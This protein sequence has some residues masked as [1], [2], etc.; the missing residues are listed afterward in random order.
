MDCQHKLTYSPSC[1][2]YFVYSFKNLQAPAHTSKRGTAGLVDNWQN[3]IV[4][5]ITQIDEDSEEVIFA[6]AQS[7]DPTTKKRVYPP[8]SSNL[9]VGVTASKSLKSSRSVG[10]S[11]SSG[12]ASSSG[13]STRQ[14]QLKKEAEIVDVYVGLEDEDDSAERNAAR[15]SPVKGNTRLSKVVSIFNFRR[16]YLMGSPLFSKNTVHVESP[17]KIK[18][19][20]IS[21]LT[22]ADL[23]KG[24]EY[25]WR[26]GFVT[27]Y[28]R[29]LGTTDNMWITN[30]EERIRVMRHCWDFIFGESVPYYI[31]GFQ[32]Y[33]YILVCCALYSINPSIYTHS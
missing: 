16:H 19:K 27:T 1:L 32:D 25:H 11:S 4:K 12:K 30:T 6:H 7:G 18:K 14:E 23:P 13:S 26:Q 21:E 24:A 15:L 8:A 3:K 10:A 9:N 20:K 29:W 28:I 33:V 22:I 5:P 17:V 31:K 2:C